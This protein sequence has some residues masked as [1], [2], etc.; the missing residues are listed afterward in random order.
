MALNDEFFLFPSAILQTKKTVDLSEM[1]WTRSNDVHK[2]VGQIARCHLIWETILSTAIYNMKS[3][4]FVLIW[5]AMEGYW[6]CI[7][8]LKLVLL[9]MPLLQAGVPFCLC[10]LIWPSRRF[11][12]QTPTTLKLHVWVYNSFKEPNDLSRTKPPHVTYDIF[13]HP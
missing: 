6:L 4:P 9:W 1:L 2:V 5:Y 10:Y 3:W 8:K 11:S 7:L 12:V 13:A